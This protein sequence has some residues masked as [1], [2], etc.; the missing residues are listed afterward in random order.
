MA[1]LT[2][3]LPALET[4]PARDVKGVLQVM[5]DIEQALAPGDVVADGIGWFNR[6]YFTVTEAVVEAAESARFENREYILALDV[7]FANLYFAALGAFVRDER[8]PRVPRAWWP[9]F[10]G[11][12]RT[13]VLPIQFALAGMNAHINRDLPVALT[14]VWRSPALELPSRDAQKLDYQRVNN[15]LAAVEAEI[16]AWFLTGRW[17]VA[18][19]ALHGADDLVATFSVVE[20]REAA[21]A[22]GEALNELGGPDGAFGGAYLEA[23]DGVVGLAGRGLLHR[24]R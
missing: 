18:D 6:L 23:L 1:S 10:S 21:W 24:T 8:S 3:L 13:D 20:A 2:S 17:A 9:L 19:Q 4:T 11:H 7:A 14:T 16:K 22:Q 15:V 12:E 5:R